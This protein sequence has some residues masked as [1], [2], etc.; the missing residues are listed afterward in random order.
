[1]AFSG[2]DLSWLLFTAMDTRTPGNRNV[3]T[4]SLSPF[5]L[6]KPIQLIATLLQS[7]CLERKGWGGNPELSLCTEMLDHLFQ[8]HFMNGS[9]D[10]DQGSIIVYNQPLSQGDKGQGPGEGESLTK[11]DTP[12]QLDRGG[13][14]AVFKQKKVRWG[15]LHILFIPPQHRH[16]AERENNDLLIIFSFP[17]EWNL[18]LR[19]NVKK[20]N[21]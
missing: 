10:W 7:I 2:P 9:V 11:G 14:P 21:L 16:L 17:W 5:T 18:F 15:N 20:K 6:S 3:Q 1:M 4:Y 12:S 19:K 8:E 13:K